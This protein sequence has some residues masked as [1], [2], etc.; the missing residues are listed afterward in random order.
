[1]VMRCLDL[2]QKIGGLMSN[3]LYTKALVLTYEVCVRSQCVF[4]LHAIRSVSLMYIYAPDI[5]TRTQI[6]VHE[7]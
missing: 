4:W 2:I 5:P 1:M 6:I 7:I 3:N